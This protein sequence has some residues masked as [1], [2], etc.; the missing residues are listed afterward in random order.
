MVGAMAPIANWVFMPSL[1]LTLIPGLL[2]IAVTP[3]Y[4]DA[5][6][7]WVKAATG[8]LIFEGGLI[9][10]QGPIQDIANK[11][12]GALAAHLDPAMVARTFASER[13]TLWVLMAVSLAN[14]VL[15]VWRPRFPQYPV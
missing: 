10:V 11:S 8:I 13:N 2:A 12:A 3:G 1:V 5:G 15:G 7:V 4:Q 14:V 6:W 9:S